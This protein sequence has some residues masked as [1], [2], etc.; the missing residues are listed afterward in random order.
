MYS[1]K[2]IIRSLIISGIFCLCW[3]PFIF[4]QSISF[5]D[6]NPKYMTIENSDHYKIAFLKK[7]GAI[8]YIIDKSTSQMVSIGS[9]D[10]SL[11]FARFYG[12]YPNEIGGRNYVPTAL[13]KPEFRYRWDSYEKELA[14]DYIPDKRL[15]HQATVQVKI[16]PTVYSYFDMTIEVQNDWGDYLDYVHFP[17][18][19]LFMKSGLEEILY[20]YLPGVLFNEEFFN[21][22]FAYVIRYPGGMG[23]FADYISISSTRGKM[24]IYPMYSYDEIYPS[25]LGL[26]NDDDSNGTRVYYQHAFACKTPD[27][28]KWTSPPVRIYIGQAHPETITYYARD[29]GMEGLNGIQ[30]KLGDLYQ[31][32]TESVFYKINAEYVEIPFSSYVQY[33]AKIPYPGIL[34][35]VAYQERG[36]DENHPDFLPP[37]PMWGTTEDFIQMFKSAQAMGFLVAPYI[38]PT[39]WDDESRTVRH[40]PSGITINDISAIDENGNPYYETYGNRGGYVVSPYSQ[41]VKQRLDELLNQFTIDLPS[42]LIF[43]DQVGARPWLFDFNRSSPVPLSY[44][45]GWVDHANKHSGKL[46]MTEF[47]FDRLVKNIIGYHGSYILSSYRDN[48]RQFWGEGTWEPYP[49][50]GFILKDKV[51]LY[52]HNLDNTGMSTEKY[53]LT[54]NAAMGYQCSFE[55]SPKIENDKSWL[56]ILGAFQKYVFSKYASEKVID[57][58]EL[59]DNVARVEFETVEVIANWRPYNKFQI[60]GVTIPSKGFLV[61]SKNGSL[62]AG[63]FR[64]LN[65]QL[66]SRDEFIIIERGKRSIWIR[67]FPEIDTDLKISIPMDWKQYKRLYVLAIDCLGDV[68]AKM[69]YD[70]VSDSLIF[71]YNNIVNNINID[72]YKITVRKSGPDDQDE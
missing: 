72:H 15:P 58:K 43:E 35:P 65:D 22:N 14:M 8:Y 16:K 20:P 47:G 12:N 49:M 40:L 54:W 67:K 50:A 42:D 4:S 62:T 30:E 25:T 61:R 60:D 53:I 41:Y 37:D 59:E 70:I 9:L 66:F 19:L 55:I 6:S 46:L 51:L 38:N 34:H 7:N 31:K 39:W 23:A 18:N 2:S 32:V 52:Q 27:G 36:F 5:D 10:Q 33:L 56:K 63:I 68:V 45:K 1:I 17:A 48:L 26:I 44:S 24:A 71:R 57:Y 29:N 69:P 3:I 11:W 64:G 13:Y 21:R 28:Q